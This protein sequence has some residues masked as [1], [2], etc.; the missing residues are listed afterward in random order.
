MPWKQTDGRS[1]HEAVAV[2]QDVDK[3]GLFSWLFL[4][5]ARRKLKCKT[6]Q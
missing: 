5:F 3:V 1:E 6:G 2:K 4:Y